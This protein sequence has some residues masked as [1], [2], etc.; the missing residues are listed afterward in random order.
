MYIALGLSIGIEMDS[1]RLDRYY[2]FPSNIDKLGDT[3]VF[4]IPKK[5]ATLKG[6]QKW[7]DI[8]RD[9]VRNTISY[10]KRRFIIVHFRRNKSDPYRRFNFDPCPCHDSGLSCTVWRCGE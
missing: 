5:N 4:V 7:K 10:C 9:F 2:S 1:I 6:L 8:M 3:K